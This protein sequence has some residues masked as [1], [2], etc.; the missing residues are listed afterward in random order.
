MAKDKRS[1]VRKQQRPT[2]KQTA[3]DLH[4][5]LFSPQPGALRGDEGRFEVFSMTDYSIPLYLAGGTGEPQHT[6]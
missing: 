5:E 3:P 2:V 1:A 6:R 4:H